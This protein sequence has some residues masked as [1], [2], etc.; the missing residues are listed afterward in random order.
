MKQEKKFLFYI[1]RSV[2]KSMIP[3]S[4]W[5]SK[6]IKVLS[7]IIFILPSIKHSIQIAIFHSTVHVLEEHASS[8]C[9]MEQIYDLS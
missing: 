7:I 1:M 9:K 8:K 4:L 2:K 6:E 3:S 5:K